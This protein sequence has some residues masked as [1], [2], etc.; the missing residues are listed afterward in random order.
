[1]TKKTY[2]ILHAVNFSEILHE[3]WKTLMYHNSL[4][5]SSNPIIVNNINDERGNKDNNFFV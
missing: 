2:E 1:M 5:M 4:K 3:A